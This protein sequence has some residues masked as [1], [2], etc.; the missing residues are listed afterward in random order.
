MSEIFAALS[1]V[2]SD[3]SS[4]SK[5][6]RNTGQGFNFRGIDAVVNA[7]GPA[8]RKHGVIVVPRVQSCDYA[9]IEIGEKRKATAHVRVI[10]EYI[11]IAQDG[12]TIS[13]TTAGEAMD[14]GDKAT[15]K[16]M[17]VAFRIALLQALAL[18][19]SEPDPD[20]SSYERSPVKTS[21]MR[22]KDLALKIH[23][24]I[25]AAV[26]QASLKL[27]WDALKDNDSLESSW[28]EGSPTFAALIGERVA[29]M[30]AAAK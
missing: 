22:D 28:A 29:E 24:D 5:D 6:E 12:S 21:A 10:V 4:V 2:M 16:A 27:I 18:P 3:V 14:G 19:T 15:A 30:K 20:A 8:L 23:A 13:C 7:V 17:S 25:L 9:T 11:F 26:D 1:A